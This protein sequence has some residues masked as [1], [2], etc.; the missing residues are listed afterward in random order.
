M[1]LEFKD[2]S[3][4][5]WHCDS[6]NTEDTWPLCPKHFAQLDKLPE[7]HERFGRSCNHCHKRHF[8]NRDE[9]CV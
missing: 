9:K 6:I 4:K 3:C 2:R 5:C 1:S 8:I 7:W